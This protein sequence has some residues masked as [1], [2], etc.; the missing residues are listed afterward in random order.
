MSRLPPWGKIKSRVVFRN[1]YLTVR[2][3]TVRQP[4]GK[5]GRY[6]YIDH[7][8][9]AGTVVLDAKLLVYLLEE[10][11]YPV[12]SFGL[13]LPSGGIDPGE[14]ALHAAK[15]ELMEEI[16]FTAK[17]WRKLETLAASDGMS[18]EIAHLF[19]AQDITTARI[20]APPLEPL[21]IIRMPLRKAVAMV[22]DGRIT[23]S[24]AIAGLVRAAANLKVLKV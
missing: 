2:E 11:K 18:T 4:D 13:H 21:T 7:G 12:R 14:T 10:Y 3:D 22:L 6:A 20:K 19:L 5:R 24:Y 8:G 16:G 17:K 23:C 15:R 9:G 1:P